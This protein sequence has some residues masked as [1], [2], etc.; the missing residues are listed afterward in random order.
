MWVVPER[1]L[2][3]VVLPELVRSLA[4][5]WDVRILPRLRAG[6]GQQF[7]DLDTVALRHAVAMRRELERAGEGVGPRLVGI[8]GAASVA[9]AVAWALES[10]S[11]EVIRLVAVD[12]GPGR[13]VRPA[14]PLS[15]FASH[16]VGQARALGAGVAGRPSYEVAF[17]GRR[18][19]TACTVVWPADVG[20]TDGTLGWAGCVDGPLDVVHVVDQ[21]AA[22]R[23]DPS[24]LA[25]LLDAALSLP[26]AP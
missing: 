14:Q 18:L 1:G 13:G 3:R 23:A 10:L 15:R 25:A 11:V 17:A 21:A 4:P 16:V 19:A 7:A 22:L 26:S 8:G 2:E 20:S 5:A 6:R 12:G 24:R 9:Y